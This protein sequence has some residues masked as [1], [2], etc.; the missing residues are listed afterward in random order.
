MASNNFL[1]VKT[2]LTG[3][4]GNVEKDTMSEVSFLCIHLVR[5]CCIHY[6]YMIKNYMYL[7]IDLKIIFT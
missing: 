6:Y 1:T 3:F 4:K 2:H 5:Y 7:I